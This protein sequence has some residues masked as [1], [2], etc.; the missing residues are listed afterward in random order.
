MD[1]GFIINE[2]RKTELVTEDIK[3]AQGEWKLV[4]SWRQLKQHIRWV[5]RER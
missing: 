4:T 2:L 1:L 3:I 5:R